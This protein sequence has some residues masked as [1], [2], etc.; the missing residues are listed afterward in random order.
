MVSEQ[1]FNALLA[2]FV[3]LIGALAE[4]GLIRPEDVSHIFGDMANAV[5]DGSEE[6]FLRWI[7]EMGV[8]LQALARDADNRSDLDP[9]D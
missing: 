9:A 8:K 7:D 1:R 6:K 5:R 2:G 4:R 3:Q